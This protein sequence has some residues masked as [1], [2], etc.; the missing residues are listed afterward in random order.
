MKL[1]LSHLN[2]TDRFIHANYYKD[3]N[4]TKT[5]KKNRKELYPLSDPR[6]LTDYEY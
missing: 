1:F 5:A 6:N 2:L 3:E 4:M